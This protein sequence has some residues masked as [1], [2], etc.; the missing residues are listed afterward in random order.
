AAP[1]YEAM[2]RQYRNRLRVVAKHWSEARLRE[3]F[4]PAERAWLEGLAPGGEQLIAAVH[5]AYL[6]HLLGLAEI[7]GWRQRILGEPPETVAILAQV[8]LALRA[9]YP[10]GV[11]GPAAQNG[12]LAGLS[13]L[14]PLAVIQEQPFRSALPLVGPWVAGFRQAW[15]RVSTEWYVKPMIQQQ[16]RFNAGLLGALHQSRHRQERLA[17]VL[18]E[19]L[20]GQARE[21]S[22]LSQELAALR[23]R[24]RELEQR[25]R[26]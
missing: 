14:E 13:E 21:I 20:A 23:A 9:F 4:L 1:G 3:E 7:A 12:P 22:A 19:Y 8:L 17:A 18:L 24:V 26:P 6:D 16:S 5:Q 15:N 11:A 25:E 2:H 10:L